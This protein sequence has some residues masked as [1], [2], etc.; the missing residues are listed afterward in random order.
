[1]LEPCLEPRENNC[2]TSLCINCLRQYFIAVAWKT[3]IGNSYQCRII[4]NSIKTP[5]NLS[6]ISIPLN[7]YSKVFFQFF[8]CEPITY[9][10]HLPIPAYLLAKSKTTTAFREP[11][12][13]GDFWIHKCLKTFSYGAPNKHLGFY[14]GITSFH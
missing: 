10:E 7:E 13:R 2:I 14:H 12:L 1:M 4:S 5:L 9:V 8:D 3:P 6:R 11:E